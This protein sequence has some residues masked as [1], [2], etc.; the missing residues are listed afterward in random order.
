MT[1]TGKLTYDKNEQII[2]SRRFLM[3]PHRSARQDRSSHPVLEGNALYEIDDACM[4]RKK[5]SQRA[6]PTPRKQKTMQ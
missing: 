2:R 5:R 3:R 6:R 1:E 4:R